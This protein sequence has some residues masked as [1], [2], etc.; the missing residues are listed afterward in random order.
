MKILGQ[1]PRIDLQLGKHPAKFRIRPL[2]LQSLVHLV[3][4]CGPFLARAG[5][6]QIH[7]MGVLWVCGKEVPM[8]SSRK[9]IINSNL[10][11]LQDKPQVC[12]LHVPDATTKQHQYTPTGP[13]AEA[14][15]GTGGAKVSGKSR[16]I[17]FLDVWPKLPAGTLVV[18]QPTS[19]STLGNNPIL[20]EVQ[21]DGCLYVLADNWEKQELN[22]A[23]DTLVGSVH[24]GTTAP[25]TIDPET[26]P[27]PE[28]ATHSDFD[29][30]PQNA[31]IKWLVA[32][33][34][35]DVSPLFQ[36][37]APA[38]QS[39]MRIIAVRKRNLHWWAWRN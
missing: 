15:L 17:I 10:L 24:K 34:R 11:P 2:V 33:F 22:L 26:S 3:N 37:D 8:C 7:S 31:K 35:L 6:D 20:Q 9:P 18:L 29:A 21:K 39:Y 28:A 12:T 27:P 23:P 25:S 36:Q 5:I 16:S 13:C 30:L 32:H 19:D 1:A 4:T 14:H 38:E